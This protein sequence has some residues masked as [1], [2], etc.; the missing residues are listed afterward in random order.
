VVK[1]LMSTSTE[2]LENLAS[3]AV[4]GDRA[5]LSELCR[6][7]SG[8]VFR[9][10]LRML[11]DPADAE[12][13]TQ[14]ILVLVV[15]HL[16]QFRAQSR[17]MTWVFTVASRHL[18]RF[19]ESRRERRKHLVASLAE[20]IDL[21]LSVTVATQEPDGDAVLLER[22]LRFLCTE[23]MLL[24]LT[25]EERLALLLVE[26]LGATDIVGAA[27]CEISADAFRKR[28]ERAR[29]KLIPLLQRRCGLSNPDNPCR[30]KRQAAA[31]QRYR[32]LSLETALLPIEIARAS[33][34][35]A[36]LS[37]VGRVFA[38]DPPLAPPARVFE[39]LTNAFPELLQ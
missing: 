4:S 21:G 12:D 36:E 32:G 6:G 27:I 7:V 22:E 3:L 14:E 19:R 15:T 8:P 33:E 5:A 29:R 24:A 9:L 34:Q 35:M 25:R 17:L 18:L 11:G 38:L 2:S 28:L 26:V 1:V 20:S 16:S 31:Q 13:A 39:A 37:A 30:C 10:A 23:G